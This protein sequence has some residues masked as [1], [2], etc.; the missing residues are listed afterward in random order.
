MWPLFEEH[1]S[2]HSAGRLV[3]EAFLKYGYGVHSDGSVWCGPVA[4]APAKIAHALGVDRRVVLAAAKKIASHESLLEVFA[5]LQ[6]RAD[7][8]ECAK[9]LGFDAIEICADAHASGIVSQVA[10]V[11][12]A[13]KAALRQVIADDPDLFSDP[14]LTIVVDGK[15]DLKTLDLLRKLPCAK[16]I[17][18][19]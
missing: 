8:S 16:K 4:M 5:T 6:P 14:K 10:G 15:L 12:A 18:I 7:F 19:R 11:L 1:F 17:T 13:R 3:V 9:A 2:R